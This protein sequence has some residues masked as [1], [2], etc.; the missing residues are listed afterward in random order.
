MGA[1]QRRRRPFQL[2]IARVSPSGEKRMYCGRILFFKVA[3]SRRV[4]MFQSLTVPSEE[5]DASVLP[6]CENATELTSSLWPRVGGSSF[7][8]AVSQNLMESS[9]L[10]VARIV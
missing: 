3:S 7:H 6:L 10:Q 1:R 4:A 9:A 8:V 5:A 2:N